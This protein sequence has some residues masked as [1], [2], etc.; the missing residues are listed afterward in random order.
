MNVSNSFHKP[1]SGNGIDYFSFLLKGTRYKL[2]Y[3]GMY[4]L[5]IP[6]TR[7]YDAGEVRIIAKNLLGEDTASTTLSVVNRH[8][9]GGTLK[10]GSREC[11]SYYEFLNGRNY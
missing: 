1:K 7:L 4:H 2:T 9:F 6:K 10:K 11:K 5:D 3:D 8:D